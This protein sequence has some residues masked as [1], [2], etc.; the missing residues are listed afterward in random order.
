MQQRQKQQGGNLTEVA[1]FGKQ[2]DMHTEQTNMY[3]G[4]CMQCAL[5]AGYAKQQTASKLMPRK[6]R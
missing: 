3:L 1:I 4:I 5:P 6:L 2:R